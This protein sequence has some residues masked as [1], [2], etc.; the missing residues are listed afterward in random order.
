MSKKV[1][2]KIAKNEKAS[3]ISSDKESLD[4]GG[5]SFPDPRK[6]S[7]EAPKNKKLD[8]GGGSFPDP[9]K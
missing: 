6:I 8:W 5:G 4:W 7:K 9:R 3:K 2:E 1:N